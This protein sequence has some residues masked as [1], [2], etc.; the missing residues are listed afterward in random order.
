MRRRHQ[1]GVAAL[2]LAFLLPVI[3]A[4]PAMAWDV[5]RAVQQMERLHH[6]VRAAVRH[7]ATGD[8]ADPTRQD[9]ARRLLVYGRV[10]GSNTPIV[11]GLQTSMVNILE[12][13][14]TPGMRLINSAAGPVSLVTVQVQGVRFVPLMLPPSWGFS[15]RPIGLTL[16]YR[17]I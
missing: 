7:L 2:E 3:V 8:A 17:F 6:G 16:A 14:S 12:P 11:P 5:G 9:E 1:S 4:V 15:F 10:Q 13:Q